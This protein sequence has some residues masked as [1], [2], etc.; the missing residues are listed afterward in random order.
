MDERHMEK[1][2]ENG[3]KGVG[4]RKNFFFFGIVISLDKTIAGI[5]IIKTIKNVKRTVL[6]LII[7]LF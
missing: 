3:K 1:E 7:C 2:G 5:I 4:N 6:N